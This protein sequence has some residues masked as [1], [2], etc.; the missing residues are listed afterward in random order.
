MTFTPPKSEAAP[1]LVLVVDDDVATRHAIVSMIIPIGIN[2]LE[3]GS[4]RQALNVMKKQRVDLV[5]SDLVMP[6]M[7]GMMLLHSMLEQGL[8][9][10]FIMTT[11]FGDKDSA[12]QALRLGAFDFLRNRLSLQR[13][14]MRDEREAARGGKGLDA[15]GG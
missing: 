11:G 4:G 12:I 9:V 8:H 1:P 6:N 3:A 15:G 14:A 7:S 2:P 5:I 10:P 13:Q